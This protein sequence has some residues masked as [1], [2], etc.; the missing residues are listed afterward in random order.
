MFENESN[1]FVPSTEQAHY[2]LELYKSCILTRN[3]EQL[4]VTDF[5]ELLFM[6]YSL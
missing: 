4:P 1:V 2:F 6:L 5:C 3:Y